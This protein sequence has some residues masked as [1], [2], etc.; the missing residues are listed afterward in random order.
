MAVFHTQDTTLR[1]SRARLLLWVLSGPL[2]LLL[3]ARV[4]TGAGAAADS[5]FLGLSC[6]FPPGTCRLG[7]LHYWTAAAQLRPRPHGPRSSAVTT[8]SRL[9]GQNGS[10]THT[11]RAQLPRGKLGDDGAASVW[12]TG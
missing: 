9:W 2:R 1:S 8:G 5:L 11:A 3:Q 4:F 6:A 7:D 10:N 12:V